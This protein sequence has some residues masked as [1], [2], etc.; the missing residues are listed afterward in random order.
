MI[1][2][3]FNNYKILLSLVDSTSRKIG[4]DFIKTTALEIKKIFN[5]KEITITKDDLK[6]TQNIFSTT[7]NFKKTNEYLSKIPIV[8][9]NNNTIGNIN[10]FS[11]SKLSIKKDLFETLMIF[12]KRIATEIKRIQLE[13]ENIIISKQ[14]E[15]LSI[16]DGLT[17]LYNRRYFQKVCSDIFEQIKKDK[18]K[19]TLAYIDIDNFKTINDTFG[20]NDGDIVLKKFAAILQNHSRKAIDYIFRLGGEEFCIISLNTPI[21]YSYEYL[22]RIMNKTI[23]EFN[24]TKYGEITLSIG[25]VEFNKEFENY[26]EIVNLADKKMYRAKKAGKNAIVK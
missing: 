15:K 10:I 18:I 5:A 11:L 19:A 16:T 9:Q 13:N 7:Y 8:D 2:T 24:T 1:N 23:E 20:H 6:K 4:K 25:L 3:D 14:L 17:T 22:A 12:A 26:S 21:N